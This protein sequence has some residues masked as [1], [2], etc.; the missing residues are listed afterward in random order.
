MVCQHNM[1]S[2]CDLQLKYIKIKLVGILYCYHHLARSAVQMGVAQGNGYSLVRV[3][4]REFTRDSTM[5][6]LQLIALLAAVFVAKAKAD[7]YAFSA[8][9]L[10]VCFY[11]VFLSR[12]I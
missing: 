6:L 9:L 7:V 3:C 10:S 4:R 11:S 8:S 2:R 12:H 1:K 5:P